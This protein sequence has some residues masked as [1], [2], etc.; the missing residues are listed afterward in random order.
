MS[1]EN[2]VLWRAGELGDIRSTGIFLSSNKDIAAQYQNTGKGGKTLNAYTLRDGLKIKE[3]T[4]RWALVKELDKT[5]DKDKVLNRFINAMYKAGGKPIDGITPEQRL[6]AEAEKR[7]KNILSKQGYDGVRYLG[8]DGTD[9]AGEHQIFD[10]KSIRQLSDQELQDIQSQP[11]LLSRT[12]ATGSPATETQ[13]QAV[14]R[15]LVGTKEATA[16]INSGRV[17]IHSNTLNLSDQERSDKIGAYIDEKG[18][19]HLVLPFLSADMLNDLIDHESGHL[20]VMTGYTDGDLNKIKLVNMVLRFRGLRGLVGKPGFDDMIV[21]INRMADNGVESAVRARETVNQLI[22]NKKLT[23]E[24]RNHE[25]LAYTLEYAPKNLPIYRRILAAIRAALYRVGIKVQ[26]N[27]TDLVAM[28]RGALK[29]RAR[30]VMQYGDT[31]SSP[32]ALAYAAKKKPT[33]TLTNSEKSAS[34]IP[35]LYGESDQTYPPQMVRDAAQFLQQRTRD[36]NDGKIRKDTP[37]DNREIKRILRAEVRAALDKTGNAED[38]Y[39]TKIAEA[40]NIVALLHPEIAEDPIKQGVFLYALAATSQGLSVER[41]IKLAEK[42]YNDYKTKGKFIPVGEGTSA[43]TMVKQL[44]MFNRLV[45]QHGIERVVRFM[46]AKFGHKEIQ[47]GVDGIKA[48]ISEMFADQ[49]IF[50]SLLMGP[51]IGSFFQNLAGNLE[52]FTID[53]WVSRM[54]GRLTGDLILLPAEQEKAKNRFIASLTPN[55]R[56]N[57]GLEEELPA[58]INEL[59]TIASTALGRYL[60]EGKNSFPETAE[61]EE[62]GKAARQFKVAANPKDS[63]KSAA[64]REWMNRIAIEVADELGIQPANLQAILWYPEKELYAK[65]GVRDNESAPTD[66]AAELSKLAKQR[67]ISDADVR[68]AITAAGYVEGDDGQRGGLRRLADVYI[69]RGNKRLA[70]QLNESDRSVAANKRFSRTQAK[71]TDP[72]TPPTSGVSV[73]A[74]EKLIAPFRAQWKQSGLQVT[75]VQSVSDLPAD[76]R[77][78]LVDDQIEGFYDAQTNG[79]YLIADN[80]NGQKRAQKVLNHEVVGHWAIQNLRSAP[81]FVQILRALRQLE[82]AGNKDIARIAQQ[83]DASQPGLDATDRGSEIFAV[84]I[85]QGLHEKIGLLKTWATRLLQGFKAFLRKMGLDNNFVN[86]VT[87]NDVL[88]FARETQQKLNRGEVSQDGRWVFSGRQVAG[89]HAQ[90]STEEFKRWSH[91]NPVISDATVDQNDIGYL[92]IEGEKITYNDIEEGTDP[93]ASETATAAMERIFNAGSVQAA[94]DAISNEYDNDFNDRDNDAVYRWIKKRANKIDF[95]NNKDSAKFSTGKPFVAKVFHGSKSGDIEYFNPNLLGGN[96]KAAS[97]KKG[98]FFSGTPETPNAYFED[99]KEGLDRHLSSGDIVWNFY[100]SPNGLKNI[101]N[102]TNTIEQLQKLDSQGNIP[103]YTSIVVYLSSSIKNKLSDNGWVGDVLGEVVITKT[104][105]GWVDDAFGKEVHDDLVVAYDYSV[106]ILKDRFDLFVKEYP[107]VFNETSPT[108]YPV[109]VRMDNPYVFDQ[110]GSE[111]RETTYNDI[112]KKGKAKGHDGVVI[113]NTF[114]GGPLDNIFVAFDNKQVKGYFNTGKYGVD[115]QRLSYSRPAPIDLNNPRVAKKTFDKIGQNIM[116]QNP[117]PMTWDRIWDIGRN[118]FNRGLALLNRQQLVEMSSRKIVG[119]GRALLPS[120][121]FFENAAALMDGIKSRIKREMYDGLIEPWQR[122]AGKNRKNAYAFDFILHGSTLHQVDPTQAMREQN[123]LESDADYA[124]AVEWHGILSDKLK[125]L[126]KMS[127]IL[128]DTVSRVFENYVKINDMKYAAMKERVGRSGFGM[129]RTMLE[130]VRKMQPG[131]A[132]VQE[133][134]DTLTI[135]KAADQKDLRAVENLLKQVNR[136]KLEE[137]DPTKGGSFKISSPIV[138]TDHNAMNAIKLKYQNFSKAQKKLFKARERLAKAPQAARLFEYQQRDADGYGNLV[139]LITSTQRRAINVLV[140]R[141]S[142]KSMVPEE[143]AAMQA[144]LA[145]LPEDA[146]SLYNDIINSHTARQSDMMDKIELYQEASRGVKPYVP[147]SRFGKY[148]VFGEKMVAKKDEKGQPV[149]DDNGQPVMERQVSFSKFATIHEQK[150]AA[151]FLKAEGWT[152]STDYQVI[153]DHVKTAPSG[154]FIGEMFGFIDDTVANDREKS[155]L[156]DSLYNMYLEN[157]P[158]MSVRKHLMKRAGIAGY[159]RDALRAYGQF[160]NGSA[161][162]IA[163][164]RYADVLTEQLF[165]MEEEV[166]ELSNHENDQAKAGAIL[167]E[168]ISS[169]DWLMNPSNATWANRMTALGF[170]WYLTNPST[171]LI[172]LSQIPLLT[173]PELASKFGGGKAA[174]GIMRAMKDYFLVMNETRKMGW[175]PLN[176]PMALKATKQVQDENGQARDD[177]KYFTYTNETEYLKAIKQMETDGFTVDRA[178]TPLEAAIMQT[179]GGEYKGDMG[180]FMEFLEKSGRV[181]RSA[182]TQLAGLG[183]DSWQTQ[184]NLK[185]KFSRLAGTTMKFGAFLFHHSEVANR[186]ITA[187][188]AYRMMREKLKGLPEEQAHQQAQEYAYNAVTFTQGDYSNANRARF[189]RGDFMRVIALF[190]TFAQMMTWRLTR[191]FYQSIGGKGVDPV[192]KSQARARFG[193]MMLNIALL[194]GAM[195]LPM[196]TMIVNIVNALAP[197]DPDDPW[198]FELWMQQQLAALVGDA[199]RQAIMTGPAGMVPM[200]FGAKDGINLSP[201]LSLDIIRMW[202]RK[203]PG[204]LEGNDL[205]NN[206]LQQAAGPAFGLAFKA[207]QGAKDFKHGVAQGSSDMLFRSAESLLPAPLANVTKAWRFQTEGAQTRRG[208]KIIDDV[209]T[210]QLISQAFGFQPADLYEKY[211]QNDWINREKTG[212]ERRKKDLINGLVYAIEEKDSEAQ[213]E[214]REQIAQYNQKNPAD[215]IKPTQIQN[216]IK[217][218]RIRDRWSMN[219]M[220]IPNKGMRKRLEAERYLSDDEE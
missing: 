109:Y 10:S 50:G 42:V 165:Q 11:K 27:D 120:A 87:L 46:F 184:D 144:E 75:A 80:L 58:D 63:P 18:N 2:P 146:Q 22:K 31:Y 4:S 16:L 198:D 140:D 52:T 168:L 213:A 21:Q 205:V 88:L 26:L 197:D 3:T 129:V 204:D 124:K 5:W 173:F 40:L 115:E 70:R 59:L 149:I 38:W 102:K 97:A 76:L 96:T 199:G 34:L 6:E 127:P 64:K 214:K 169:Y 73:S 158:D 171:A 60:N 41:N 67:G 44:S 148:E 30:A 189:M 159:N 208:D 107:W 116:D 83:V 57:M 210:G 151:K 66:Y 68:S 218:R 207:A 183:E 78:A 51:K 188:A 114:D 9:M 176:P 100:F 125:E 104:K 15:S 113:T 72:K 79:V 179:L 23:E 128:A 47:T 94:L 130:R 194:G 182:T 217:Q 119:L 167:N 39:G 108:V 166:S 196:Y 219:G 89:S 55:V 156:K 212:L 49:E 122:E 111:Y 155:A 131:N 121:K 8:S 133:V 48:S 29:Q 216:A 180:R 163:R 145:K 153:R 81:E 142:Q 136:F 85:E 32:G 220:Y 143:H 99:P 56:E 195:G 201:R 117:D 157:L 181:S 150:N 92:V 215:R 37:E 112:I 17:V 123:E 84:A 45:G 25:L 185:G 105:S 139:Q 91:G 191:D 20:S 203:P 19:I 141:V 77:K 14:L 132:S 172:N 126:A 95:V 33:P 106:K 43:N 161:N 110:R 134:A 62:A 190:R 187:I 65:L 118:N 186:E 170:V 209:S 90:E 82:K 202:I 192:E 86:S 164:L 13:A 12:A 74:I 160:M 93:F 211:Q 147:L 152:V 103:K 206:Y 36:G 71:I 174:G 35:L 162:M 193:W 138:A 24:D 154:S 28:A 137:V 1:D 53:M 98:F 101:R 135:L 69:R 175:N 54:W 177:V 61:F 178:I 200:L 7:I